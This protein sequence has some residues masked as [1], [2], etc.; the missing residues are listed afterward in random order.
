MANQRKIILT[1]LDANINNEE[2]KRT[3]DT[4]REKFGDCMSFSKQSDFNRFL[5]RT[6]H[7]QRQLILIISGQ[8]GE[9]LVPDIHKES[10]ILSVYVYCSWKEKHEKWSEG[11]SK[12]RYHLEYLFFSYINIVNIGQGCY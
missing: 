12:V 10:N 7:N 1:W 3:F 8:I 2:N 6:S 5:G 4:L 9:N 11:Y